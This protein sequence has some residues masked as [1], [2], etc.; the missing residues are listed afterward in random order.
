M[1]CKVNTVYRAGIV[2][3]LSSEAMRMF[4]DFLDVGFFSKRSS[5]GFD[6]LAS[7]MIR[8]KVKSHADDI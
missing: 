4:L 7:Q 1:M 5:S 3:R 8:N 6:L 2:A